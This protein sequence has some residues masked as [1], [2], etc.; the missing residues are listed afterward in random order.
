M[1]R[2]TSSAPTIDDIRQYNIKRQRVLEDFSLLELQNSGRLSPSQ[3]HRPISSAHKEYI[4]SIDEFLLLNQDDADVLESSKYI[5]DFNAVEADQLV[6]PDLSLIP[7]TKAQ[8]RQRIGKVRSSD[9]RRSLEDIIREC[10]IMMNWALVPYV[11]YRLNVYQHWVRWM[12]SIDLDAEMAIDDTPDLE[13][14]NPRFDNAQWNDAYK[15][16][17]Y[18]GDTGQINIQGHQFDDDHATDD[19]DVMDI[20]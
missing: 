12:S 4:P 15:G 20:D 1:K 10:D 7:M 9:D 8:L 3:I 17:Y 13:P 19:D 2:R 14:Q 18:G 5:D 11:D 6:I 16:G